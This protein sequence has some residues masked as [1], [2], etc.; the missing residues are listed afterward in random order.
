[1]TVSTILFIIGLLLGAVIGWILRTAFDRP[2]PLLRQYN[3]NPTQR[4]WG[5]R[6]TSSTTQYRERRFERKPWV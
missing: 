4:D 6:P 2:K 1:M 3:G 5:A